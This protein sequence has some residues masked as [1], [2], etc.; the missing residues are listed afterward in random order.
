MF[1]VLNRGV[2]RMQ[3][4]EKAGDYEAL[5]RVLAET[6]Q[7]APMRVCSY[8]VMPN[9]WH[10]LLWPEHD[11]DMARFMQ[12]MTIQ[13]RARA[14]LRHTAV[15][16]PHREASWS[17]IGIPFARSSLNRARRESSSSIV[18]PNEALPILPKPDLS[19]F[20]PPGFAPRPA[21][22]YWSVLTSS[23]RAARSAGSQAA[24]STMTKDAAKIATSTTG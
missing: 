19:P 23:R 24:A 18:T 17:G 16:A 6:L 11:G 8:C 14:P 15:A 3:L 5:E 22:S 4:F 21:H 9:H 20:L 13:R 10:M 1:H 7:E 12:R 2:A